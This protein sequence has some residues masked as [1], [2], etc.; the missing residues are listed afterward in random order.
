MIVVVAG[1]HASRQHT[2]SSSGV[3]EC[4]HRSTVLAVPVVMEM[5]PLKERSNSSQLMR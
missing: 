1:E 4:P 5:R 2:A 3:V